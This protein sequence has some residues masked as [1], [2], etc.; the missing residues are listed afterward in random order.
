MKLI[1]IGEYSVLIPEQ[2]T[3]EE[4]SQYRD[5]PQMLRHLPFDWDAVRKTPTV[6]TV[7]F[8]ECQLSFHALPPDTEPQDLADALFNQTRVRPELRDA[9]INGIPGKVAGG[10]SD[11]FSSEEWWLKQG[12]HGIAF[13]FR[14]VG[15]VSKEMKSEAEKILHSIGY[16]GHVA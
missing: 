4:F 5:M 3:I 15:P 13:H 16:A 8:G 11:A 7:R 10:Y 14:G 6:Y 2:Y 12:S 1:S 9:V